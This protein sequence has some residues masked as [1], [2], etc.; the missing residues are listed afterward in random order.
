MFEREINCFS[1]I[2]S[3]WMSFNLHPYM[4]LNYLPFGLW[5]KVLALFFHNAIPACCESA[6]SQSNW[7]IQ[8]KQ[9][10]EDLGKHVQVR[11]SRD[12]ACS[13]YVAGM[14]S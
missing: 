8:D 9:Q 4:S 10:E 12:D 5:G 13:P 6:F 11:F 3:I 7:P 14:S 1:D 2:N